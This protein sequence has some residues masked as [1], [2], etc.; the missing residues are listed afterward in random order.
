MQQLSIIVV[1]ITFALS[2]NA[3]SDPHTES[4]AVSSNRNTPV[5]LFLSG[6]VMLGRGID[7]ILPHRNNPIL[8]ERYMRD[9]RD[10]VKLA[11]QTNGPIR[12]PVD[13][14]YIW[15]D[16]I[17]IMDRNMPDVRIIN[18]E[19]SITRSDD[20]W[21]N[22]GIHYRMHPDNTEC[23]RTAKIDFTSLA[24]NHVL[25]WGYEG[26]A[27]TLSSIEQAGIHA[28]GAGE[29]RNR[30]ESPSLVNVP[31]KA[32]VIITAWASDY[33]GVPSAWVATEQRPGVN[34]LVSLDTEDV[35]RIA[36]S[37]RK[38]KKTGDIVVL[39][40]HWGSNWGY[41][42]PRE[43]IE[44]ARRLIDEA[45][46]DVVH[47][48][49]SHH[50]KGIEVYRNK[51]IIYGSGDLLNDYEGIGG[52]EAY[53]ADLALMYFADIDPQ[54]GNLINLKMAPVQIKNLRIN[55]ANHADT[56]WLANMLNREGKLFGTQVKQR[57]DRQFELEWE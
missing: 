20:A 19:T 49:S 16:A 45:G 5:T 18:L 56:A 15:G 3:F 37:I 48:H 57:P 7:Q 38:H 13:C 44:F 28:A 10:Y 40:I 23:L 17:E 42:I 36:N 25:D 39:T 32:R 52:H 22:K 53:R 47:G 12:K 30:A 43:Q 31:G 14:R 8:Y 29:N 46:V 9:A 24:N 41:H 34:R 50:A 2:G 35:Q 26:L 4:D 21:E 33:S 51:L 27:E 11:E 55:H 6:D 54:T 1:L